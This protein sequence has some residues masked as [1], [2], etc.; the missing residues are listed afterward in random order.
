[1]ALVVQARP[2]SSGEA[3]HDGSHENTGYSFTYA[4][5]EEDSQER[6]LSF[7]QTE[8]RSDESDRTTGSYYVLLPDTRLMTVTYYV[9]DEGFHPTVTFE[10]EAVHPDSGEYGSD[11]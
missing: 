8:N 10:G 3:D 4:I 7:G 1:M 11:E 2:Q 9:D 6:E 5:S